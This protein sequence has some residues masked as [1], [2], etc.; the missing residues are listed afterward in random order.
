MGGRVAD[1]VPALP[2]WYDLASA[3]RDHSLRD[4]A[5]SDNLPNE[6]RAAIL[7]D[8]KTNTYDLTDQAF[9]ARHPDMKGKKLER[10]G[11]RHKALREEYGAMAQQ[12]GALIWLRQLIDELDKH[13]GDIP[14]EFAG[15][16]GGGIR[17]GRSGGDEPSRARIFSD[18]L[19]GR[20]AR[21]ARADGSAV[22][23]IEHGPGVSIEK[24]VE[25]VE[26]PPVHPQEFPRRTGRSSC[27]G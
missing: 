24:G 8:G 5:D 19:A 17:T 22:P 12:V 2:P 14:R 18:R 7:R 21:A 26:V 11:A 20:R 1:E 16:D 6:T 4:I 13:S 10:T 27:G 3:P 9:W 15:L 23:E 25:L